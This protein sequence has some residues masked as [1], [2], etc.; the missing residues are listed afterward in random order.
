MQPSHCP[1]NLRHRFATVLVPHPWI[2]AFD[3]ADLLLHDL[4]GPYGP[5]SVGTTQLDSGL[6]DLPSLMASQEAL[7]AGAGHGHGQG[8]G[9]AAA[10]LQ[11]PPQ[12]ARALSLG[13]SSG[14]GRTTINRRDSAHCPTVPELQSL[15]PEC[16]L[17]AQRLLQ[18]QQQSLQATVQML[19]QAYGG[20]PTSGCSVAS[21]WGGGPGSGQVGPAAAADAAAGVAGAAG[22]GA[23]APPSASRLTGVSTTAGTPAPREARIIVDP[24]FRE[25]F[26]IGKHATE[27]YEALVA[28]LPRV[29]VGFDDRLP[30]LVELLCDEMAAA[31]KERSVP[32]PPWRRAHSLISKWRPRAQSHT[33][34]AL[35]PASAP[36][37]TGAHGAGNTLASAA[38]GQQGGPGT[39]AGGAGGMGAVSGGAGARPGG[40]GAAGAAASGLD[41]MGMARGGA[42]SMDAAAANT[43]LAGALP[44]GLG[45]QGARE[46]MRSRLAQVM[47]GGQGNWDQGM[48]AWGGNKPGSALAALVGAHQSAVTAQWPTVPEPQQQLPGR[49]H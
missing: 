48:A 17:E 49:Q 35:P 25:Q 29:Y 8:Q 41:G 14:A 12:L 34:L 7:A 36:A 10:G 45:M 3:P 47:A 26:E 30:L 19:Q 43:S 16:A 1:Q 13:R 38:A 37:V 21:G 32:V 42:V 28:A 31:F 39:G 2:P 27:A 20:G 40:M 23:G 9:G 24:S 46:E 5:M 18:A 15:N 44:A 33:S 6:S 22:S 11:Q 4:H